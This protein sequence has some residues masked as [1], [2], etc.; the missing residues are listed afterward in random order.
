[1]DNATRYVWEQSIPQPQQM[2]GFEVC[3]ALD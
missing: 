3:I 1:M 2:D